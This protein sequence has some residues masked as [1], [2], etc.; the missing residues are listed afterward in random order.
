MYGPYDS[1]DPNKAHALNALISKFV[2]AEY[3]HE[4][5][6]SIWGTGTPIREWLYA[7]DFARLVWAVLQNPDRAGLEQPTNLAQNDGLSVRAL[8]DIIQRK[9]CYHGQ[10]TWDTSMADGAPKKVMD[11]AKFRQVFPEFRF[12]KFKKGI[13]ETIKYYESI[14]P[15]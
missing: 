7:C 6:L 15:Y 2:K 8:V 10:L 4:P 1:T 13:C 14:F 3:L 5:E 9:F 12:T 11:N